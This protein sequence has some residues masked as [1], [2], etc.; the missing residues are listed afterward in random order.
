MC[1]TAKDSLNAYIFNL[2]TSS[3][4]FCNS[5]SSD[6]KIIAIFLLWVGQMQIFD[7]IFWTNKD[8][9]TTNKWATKMA[10]LFNHLQPLVLYFLVWYYKHPQ[11]EL[12]KIIILLYSIFMI[13]YTIK[14]WPDEKCEQNKNPVCCSLP[15]NTNDKETVIDW[16]WNVQPNAYIVYGLFLTSLVANSWDLKENKWL[17]SLISLGSYFVSTK[18]PILSQSVGRLWC[19][20]ASLMPGFIL[21]FDKILK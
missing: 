7:Y 9:G 21:V 19:Y 6:M 5:E 20:F 11:S 15:F 18:I 4:L 12:S 16:K 3:L 17:F 14:L 13:D 8:C 2:I 1:Y 10:I